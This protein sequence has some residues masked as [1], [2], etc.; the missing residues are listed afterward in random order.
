MIEER[1]YYCEVIKKHF[2]KELVMTKKD[3]ADLYFILRTPLK[4]GSVTMIM[5]IMMLKKEI[6][7]I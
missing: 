3:N 2:N 6:I 4:L 1:K 5:L 7:V